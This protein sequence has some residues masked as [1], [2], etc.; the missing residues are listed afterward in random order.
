MELL[1]YFLR[2]QG[3]GAG[4]E[5]LGGGERLPDAIDRGHGEGALAVPVLQ[6]GLWEVRRGE[7]GVAPGVLSPSEASPQGADG[8]SRR[9]L[10]GV[11]ERGDKVCVCGGGEKTFVLVHAGASR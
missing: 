2:A 3:R 9:G 5:E 6:D 8:S 10:R 7:G 11:E 4:T 1:E